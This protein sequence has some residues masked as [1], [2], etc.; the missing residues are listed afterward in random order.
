MNF[1]SLEYFTVL[2]RERNFTRAAEQL[3]IT[4]QTLSAHIAGLEKELGCPLL[5]RRTP[6]ELT[7]A[8]STFL[9][10]AEKMA[11]LEHSMRREF[12][13][14]AQNQKGELRV[15]VAFTRGRAIMPQ[16][17]EVF[18]KSYPQV[19]IS[20]IEDSN[21]ALQKQLQEGK[22]DLAVAN[23]P[24]ELPGIE[25]R[26]FYSEAVVL[27]LSKALMQKCGLQ[28]AQ[29]RA[30]AARGRLSLL[31]DCPFVFGAAEDI[32]G[33]IGRSLLQSSGIE[34]PVRA[35]SEN[36]ETLL[37]LC[38]RGVGACF[39]PENLMQTALSPS[40]REKLEIFPLSQAAAYRIRFGWQKQSYQ[41]S[42][43][44]QFVK[45]AQST[46]QKGQ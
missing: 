22:L 39:S 7:Y 31:A 38:V 3:H 8:G 28:A 42:M 44:E 25:L 30:E 11:G 24:Q 29:L 6:L 19:Q 20:L 16:A 43:I 14:I 5:L 26:E 21:L 46:L 40:Q 4:Q 12:C 32:G 34:P 17:I 27:C 15:G 23:F 2:A 13:D 35:A 45:A 37:E 10:Y 1:S 36:I 18:Q 33:T 41:W 9:R